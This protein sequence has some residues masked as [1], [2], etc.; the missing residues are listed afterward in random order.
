LGNLVE[1]P[2][3]S[4]LINVHA[5]LPLVIHSDGLLVQVEVGPAQPASMQMET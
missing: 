3:R 4:Q 2:E 1:R 5:W